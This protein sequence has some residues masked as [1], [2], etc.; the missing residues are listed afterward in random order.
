MPAWV[1]PPVLN[2]FTRLAVEMCAAAGT[3]RVAGYERG[4]GAEVAHRATEV[5]T[6]E[7]AEAA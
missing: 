3:M 7:A 1:T 5:T 2:R 4:R 6:V